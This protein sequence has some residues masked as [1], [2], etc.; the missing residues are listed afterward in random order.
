MAWFV[1][2]LLAGNIPSDPSDLKEYLKQLDGEA[3][4]ILNGSEKLKGLDLDDEAD[5]KHALD[6]LDEDRTSIEWWAVMIGALVADVR[7]RMSSNDTSG[8][9]VSSLR[10]Q[11]SRSMV[12]FKQS[13]EDH[14]WTG[15]EHAVWLHRIASAATTSNK[16]AER[17]QALDALFADVSEDVLYTWV[18]SSADIGPRLGVEGVDESDLRNLAEFYLNRFEQKRRERQQEREHRRGMWAN[19]I[20]GAG[21]GQRSQELLPP[22]SQRPLSERRTLRR[23]ELAPPFLVVTQSTRCGAVPPRGERRQTAC[24]RRTSGRRL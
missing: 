12:V 2:L 21:V 13:L 24:R 8:A 3:D 10:L 4:A 19:R 14:V 1:S 9:I 11:A 5:A 6:I 20:A 23:P 7:E 15:Y 18:R 16:E 22:C 17:I